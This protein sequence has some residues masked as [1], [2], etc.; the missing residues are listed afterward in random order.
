[1]EFEPSGNLTI[2]DSLFALEVDLEGIALAYTFEQLA[3]PHIQARKLKRVLTSYSPTFPGFYLYYPR[4]RQQP[5]KLK[6]FI[7]YAL[8]HGRTR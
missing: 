7:G 1:M 2:S 3:L 6:A 5:L 4:R 8:K